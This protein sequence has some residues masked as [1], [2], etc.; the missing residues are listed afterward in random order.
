V[1]GAGRGAAPTRA[2]RPPD[3]GSSSPALAESI[4]KAVAAGI[5]K[6]K[7]NDPAGRLAELATPKKRV[8]IA[9]AARELNLTTAQEE[10]IREA[11]KHATDRMLK[12]F[13]EPEQTPEELRKELEE[14][15]GDPGR[16]AAITMKF[17]PKMLGKLGDVMAIQTE[18]DAKVRKAV[19]KENMAKLRT[20]RLAEDDEFGLGDD[21]DEEPFSFGVKAG[22]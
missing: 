17:L 10:E 3:R 1:R 2:G 6:A 22:N 12:A 19:G 16:R 8:T 13:A 15:K 21:D 18:R 4:E 5:A 20:Y 14:A 7:A 9:E 11:Y